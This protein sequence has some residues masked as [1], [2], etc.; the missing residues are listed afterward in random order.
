MFLDLSLGI[1]ILFRL[2]SH[3]V[4][5]NHLILL[6]TVVRTRRLLLLPLVL[7]ITVDNFGVRAR[8]CIKLLLQGTRPP[9]FKLASFLQNP[10]FGDAWQH[11]LTEVF[12]AEKFVND[13]VD[14]RRRELARCF[15][16]L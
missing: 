15:S 11:D 12:F 5:L 7:L 8:R 13:F 14:M 16:E 1:G 10:S 4:G 2:L 3:L 9:F 6:A